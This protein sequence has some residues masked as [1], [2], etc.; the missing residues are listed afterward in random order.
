VQYW[1][2]NSGSAQHPYTRHDWRSTHGELWPTVN[3]PASKKPSARTGDRMFWHAIGSGAW[4]GEGRIF[5]LGQVT[6]HPA[7]WDESAKDPRWPWALPV[8]ILLTV[9]LLSLGPRL[10]DFGKDAR[11]LRR[12]SY[13]RL[14]PEQ[15]ELAEK[16]LRAAAE[17][18]RHG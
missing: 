4:L 13:V 8:Q 7:Y 5:A 14:T 3:F 12:Q 18:A 6:D 9:P 10:S 11:S 2:K 15:G 16:L 1:L 17:P